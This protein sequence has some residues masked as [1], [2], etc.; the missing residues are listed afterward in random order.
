MGFYIYKYVSN[1]IIQYIGKTTDLDRRLSEHTKDKLAHF[2]G[3]IYY[4]ECANTTAMNS[5]EY[6][7]I[8]KYHPKYNIASND[9]NI[10]INIDEPKWTLY[11][12]QIQPN[13]QIIDI[14]DYLSQHSFSKMPIY[15][16][17]KP[18]HHFRCRRCERDFIT[19]NWHETKTGYSAI[20]KCGYSVFSRG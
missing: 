2:K 6:C 8:N 14:K 20:C 13:I 19:T 9:I 18:S 3:D 5:W 11:T 1:N 7:L 10:N 4:F 16:S 12:R 17:S 15:N